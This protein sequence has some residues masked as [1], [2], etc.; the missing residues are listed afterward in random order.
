MESLGWPKLLIQESRYSR[1]LE[2]CLDV[3]CIGAPYTAPC[4]ER[5]KWLRRWFGLVCALNSWGSAWKWSGE[6]PTSPWFLHRDYG[7]DQAADPGKWVLQMPADMPR[8]GMERPPPTPKSRYRRGGATQA[9]KLG[10]QVLQMPGDL[11]RHKAQRAALHRKYGAGRLQVHASRFS[12]CLEICFYQ[13]D[14]IVQGFCLHSPPQ[15]QG[16][17]LQFQ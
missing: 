2:I 14:A 6:G 4:T 8:L 3:E 12:K 10:K 15:D 9:A 17:P 1:F 5:V 16:C 7:A 13:V 11:P